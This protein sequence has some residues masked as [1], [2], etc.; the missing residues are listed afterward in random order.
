MERKGK[1]PRRKQVEVEYDKEILDTVA[2]ACGLVGMQ[3][4]SQDQGPV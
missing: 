2:A 4:C 3:R 1:V